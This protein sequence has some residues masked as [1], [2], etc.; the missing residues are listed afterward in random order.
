[1]TNTG[2]KFGVIR[3]LALAVVPLFIV[4][5]GTVTFAVPETAEAAPSI[6]VGCSTSSNNGV[7]TGN[8]RLRIRDGVGLTLVTDGTNPAH[9][10]TEAVDSNPDIINVALVS[11]DTI[12]IELQDPLN[13][14]AVVRN[15]LA[16]VEMDGTRVRC[17]V[18]TPAP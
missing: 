3:R 17:S 8:L 13:G 10:H 9:D 15:A 16:T 18:R 2:S 6:G 14:N 5:F 7:T 1:M 12:L 11:S 4:A